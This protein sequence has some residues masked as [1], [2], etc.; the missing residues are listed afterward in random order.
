MFEEGWNVDLPPCA[1]RNPDTERDNTASP[2]LIERLKKLITGSPPPSDFNYEP[3]KVGWKDTVNVPNACAIEVGIDSY[4]FQCANWCWDHFSTGR[5]GGICEKITHY[6]A[7]NQ[8]CD[9]SSG[10]KCEDALTANCKDHPDWYPS[11]CDELCEENP[12][13]CQSSAEGGRGGGG[14]G[15]GGGVGGGGGTGGGGSGDGVI[16]YN[17]DVDGDSQANN[18]DPDDDNDGV[19]DTADSDDDNDGIGDAQDYIPGNEPFN[20]GST[21][22]RC[23]TVD[24]NGN[25]TCWTSCICDQQNPWWCQPAQGAAIGSCAPSEYV[26]NPPGENR[27]ICTNYR[28]I[29]AEH[30]ETNTSLVCHEEGWCDEG[31]VWVMESSSL[32][33]GSWYNSEGTLWNPTTG[34]ESVGGCSYYYGPLTCYDGPQPGL[35]DSHCFPNGANQACATYCGCPTNG[36]VYVGCCIDPGVFSPSL[37]DGFIY[38]C[39]MI[40]NTCYCENSYEYC[41]SPP[42]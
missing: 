34:Y 36:S 41:I 2:S 14:D 3:P 23:V 31:W 42:G 6:D 32:C 7:E 37:P 33:Q 40:G 29:H 38:Y 4:S 10:S 24:Q 27:H 12:S 11:A 28:A 21:T 13:Q 15:E 20:P 5:D 19:A 35:N 16:G 22:N 30:W 9:L 25:E 17:N 8:N 1:S 26:W 18:A 39:Q